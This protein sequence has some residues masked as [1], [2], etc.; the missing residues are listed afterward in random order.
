M[1]QEKY[2]IGVDFGTESGR[3]VVVRVS[4][5]AELGSAVHEYADGVIDETLP[6]SGKRLPPEWALQNPDDYIAVFQNAV[7]E[8][9][10][11]SG[12]DPADV[13]GGGLHRLH[14]DAHAGWHA[15]DAPARW[16]DNPMGQTVEAPPRSR[17]RTRSVPRRAKWAWAGST[18]W[19]ISSEWFFSKVLQSPTK[20]PVTA[21]LTVDRSGGSGSSGTA[22]R[23]RRATPHRGLQGD[24]QTA[25]PPR[26]ILAALHPRRRV[27]TKMKRAGRWAAGGQ[28]TEAARWTGL[29]RRAGRWRTSTRD[30][31]QPA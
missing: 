30:R 12:V 29:H 6:T 10:R 31:Q 20:H 22:L 8:A 17:K 27:D 25:H 19:Q 16:R 28:L 4:D 21:R 23:R 1:S 24:Y 3:A 14:D 15:A 18:R 13:I 11:Q 9:L 2:T 26:A 5:G 7:P